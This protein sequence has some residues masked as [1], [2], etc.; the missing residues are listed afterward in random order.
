MIDIFSTLC[1]FYSTC[2][3]RALMV[4]S[5]SY[6]WVLIANLTIFFGCQIILLTPRSRGN[7]DKIWQLE[8][9]IWPGEWNY[10]IRPGTYLLLFLFL[11]LGRVGS[12]Y[13]LTTIVKVV[14]LHKTARFLCMYEFSGCVFPIMGWVKNS[15]L[16]VNSVLKHELSISFYFVW[17]KSLSIHR[18]KTPPR[19]A[20]ILCN[21]LL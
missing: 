16:K 19:S 6:V 3:T 5:E 12:Q 17:F 1:F 2:R 9:P 20:T 11:K 14:L 13:I 8:T 18:Q 21:K 7:F 15:S 10:P 4:G